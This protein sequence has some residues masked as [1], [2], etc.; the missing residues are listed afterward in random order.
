VGGAGARTEPA[1]HMPR[2]GFWKR[3]LFHFFLF[4]VELCTKRFLSGIDALLGRVLL[5]APPFGELF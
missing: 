2:N 4:H 5:A 3:S 1:R